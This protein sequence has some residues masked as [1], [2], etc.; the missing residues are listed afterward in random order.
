MKKRAFCCLAVAA[1]LTAAFGLSACGKD[2]ET[3]GNTLNPTPD[4]VPEDPV[5]FDYEAPAFGNEA[6]VTLSVQARKTSDDEGKISSSLFGVFLEDINYASYYL[7]DNLLSN[8]SFE[9]LTR[10]W[11]QSWQTMSN[12]TMTLGTDGGVLSN[13]QYYQDKN[14]NSKYAK[15]VV[16]ANGDGGVKNLGYNSVVP[17]ALW[18]GTEY[19]FSAFIKNTKSAFDMT[20]AVTNGTKEFLSGT[21]AV[22]K[23]SE[24][25]K[26]T[27]TFTA[28]GT[29][30]NG[31]GFELRIPAGKEISLDGVSLETTDST[32]GIKNMAYEAIRDLSPKFIRFPGGCIIEGDYEQG[33]N[34]AYDWKNSIGAVQT[35]NNAGDDTV[36]EFSYT[37]N[38]ADDAT[39][40]A[41]TYGEAIA[42][43]PNPDL[44]AIR[45]NNYYDMTYAIGFYDYFLLCDSLGAS[46]VPVLNCGLSCQGGVPQSGYKEKALPGRHSKYLEDYIRDAVDLI[47]FAKGDTNTK[48]GK[49]RADMGHPAPFKMDYLGIGNEQWGIYYTNYYEKFLEDDD[50]MEA[51]ET[52]SVKPIVGNGVSISDCQQ[53]SVGSAKGTAQ[54]R[55]ET[56]LT[57]DA[58]AYPNRKIETIDEYGVVDQHYYVNYTTLLTK[59]DMYDRYARYY[60]EGYY[61]V[62]VGE[63]SANT[64]V[65][66]YTY[67]AN[68]WMTALSEAAMMTGYERNGDVVKLAAYAP[69]FGTAAAYGSG[70][71]G[72]QWGTD[73]M[74]FTNTDL[75]LSTNYYVQ[76]L[77]MKNQ[78]AYKILADY[79]DIEW[80]ND[81]SPTF[82]LVADRAGSTTTTEV[83]KL[84]YVAS[85]AENG[86]VIVKIVNVSGD[87]IKTDFAISDATLKGNASVTVLQ[88]D[89]K[90]AKNTLTE[91]KVEP[92]SFKIGVSG[93]IFGY[94]IK[95]YSVISFTVHTK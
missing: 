23:S 18:E 78:G 60:E 38:T 86:D 11:N 79:C 21:I 27:R 81:L 37:L 35:G 49:I 89:D 64:A 88:C 75:V 25:V 93:S 74:Y 4:P 14:T 44:W 85:L 71:L 43:T 52:Y 91:T 46:A 48:W 19:V 76:Q 30:S 22:A 59:T 73:M 1:A 70:Q 47:E 45:N 66:D 16:S 82:R 90:G 56:Y 20:V 55:A 36:P 95:P 57:S 9:S 12:T 15:I 40:T 92:E 3:P 13:T 33:A 29:E 2:D 87:S 51:L 54:R 28:T 61:E 84:Y 67:D 24:W 8:G 80:H 10:S 62:F 42:R 83:N 17:I 58:S 32:I 94:E 7:D 5:T 26:Y 6:D 63:Y 77:F 68:Q 50:F 41:K 69:M 53:P 34:C 65:G 31:L 72:N 39:S